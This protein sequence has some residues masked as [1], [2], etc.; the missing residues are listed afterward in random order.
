MGYY[1]GTATDHA[2]CYAKVRAH[3][4][5]EGWT[6]SL[7]SNDNI[8]E[9]DGLKV[10]LVHNTSGS[11]YVNNKC[12]I[13]TTASGTHNLGVLAVEPDP[14]LNMLYADPII[15]Y[16]VFIDTGATPTIYLAME[17]L[18]NIW[19]HVQ[20][21]IIVKLGGNGAW[22]GGAFLFSNAVGIKN[23]W[24][25]WQNETLGV[26]AQSTS[27]GDDYSA[28]SYT[29]DEA[30]LSWSICYKST[31]YA[32]SLRYF[33]TTGY[34]LTT[35]SANGSS[36]T[37]EGNILYHQ[38]NVATGEHVLVPIEMFVIRNGGF[39]SRIGH[40]P[41]VFLVSVKG[42]ID[43]ETVVIN[44]DTYRFFPVRAFGYVGDTGLTEETGMLG[45]AY[46]Q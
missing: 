23:S 10:I 31:T 16:H 38:P 19:R 33:T 44:A 17:I 11:G 3:A 46:K 32:A 29:D 25:S 24:S 28:F 45:Y 8:F 26:A 4:T 27:Y 21:G 9:K 40:L 15:S 30:V 35:C 12:K 13:E 5:L 42:L 20:F 43:A 18:P 6:T 41:N 7:V 36:V 2:D 37:P 39:W 22:V 1:T 34:H 14:F